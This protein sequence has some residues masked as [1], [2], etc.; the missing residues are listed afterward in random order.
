MCYFDVQQST[1]FMNLWYILYQINALKET[2]CKI[3]H[4]LIKVDVLVEFK[5]T[6]QLEYFWKT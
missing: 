3:N 2:R 4:L 5:N 6:L 1:A